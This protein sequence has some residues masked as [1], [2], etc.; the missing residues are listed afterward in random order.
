MNKQ[1][2]LNMHGEFSWGYSSDWFIETPKGNFIWSDS[3]YP[4]GNNHI[5][6]FNGTLSDF[7]ALKGIPYV[8]DKGITVIKNRVPE[9]VTIDFGE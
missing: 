5:K 1:E 7:L 9:T 3:D 8:R 4:L 6:K 2:F